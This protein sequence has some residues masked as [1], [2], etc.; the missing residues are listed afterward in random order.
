MSHISIRPLGYGSLGIVDEVRGKYDQTSHSLVRKVVLLR[1]TFRNELVAI[2]KQEVAI[3]RSLIHEHIVQV[4]GTYETLKTPRQLGILLSPAGDENLS[5]YLERVGDNGYFTEDL[6]LLQKWISCLA[7]TVAYIHAQ[8]VRHKD[9]KPSN[10]ICKGDQILH[11]FW[12]S[13]SIYIRDD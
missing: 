13:T 5:E 1:G 6:Q 12:V 8:N 7:S 3:M 2:M 4:V 9:I 10:I 11:R